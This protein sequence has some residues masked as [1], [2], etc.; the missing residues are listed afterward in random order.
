[1]KGLFGYPGFYRIM[2]AN[3]WPIHPERMTLAAD[4]LIKGNQHEHLPALSYR[5]HLRNG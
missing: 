5:I 4:Q 3:R 2:Q 1:M